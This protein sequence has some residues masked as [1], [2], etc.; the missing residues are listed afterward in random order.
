MTVLWVG[1]EA[2]CY[3]IESGAN[4]ENGGAS[5]AGFERTGFRIG[6]NGGQSSTR[7]DFPAQNEIWH[8]FRHS[9]RTVAGQIL[10]AAVNGAGTKVAQLTAVTVSTA[11]FSV[12]GVNVGPVLDTSPGVNGAVTRYDIHLL[13]QAAGKVE[14]YYGTPG[15]QVKILDAAGDYSA[16]AGIVRCYHQANTT[17]GGYDTDVGHAVIQTTPTL[18]TT[19]EVH[20]PTSQGADADGSGD[21]TAID[22]LTYSDADL[23]TLPAIG[24]HQS[25]KSP[26]RTLTQTVVSGV[27]VSWRAWYEAGGP[28]SVKPYLTIAGV[29]YYGPAFALDLVAL[30][31]QYTWQTNPATGVAFTPAE[32]NDATLEWG[33]EAAA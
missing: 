1:H 24:N 4:Q 9:D 31:Y 21:Y 19:S 20:P 27:T 10:W 22:E 7:P 18:S 3:T 17:G 25:Y 5:E 6:R 30:G 8:R 26:A 11:Q 12:N 13:A 29:R 28:A 14:I 15:G 23:V 32:A 2:E 16:A 33:L